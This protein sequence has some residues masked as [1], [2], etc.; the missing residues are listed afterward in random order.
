MLTGWNFKQTAATLRQGA[1]E[2]NHED[3]LEKVR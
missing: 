3:E 1:D 2:V